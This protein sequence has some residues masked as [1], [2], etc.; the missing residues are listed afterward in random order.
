MAEDNV[1]GASS[2]KDM[3]P[4]SL[5]LGRGP[6][7]RDPQPPRDYRCWASVGSRLNDV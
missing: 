1:A 4:F 5:L 2:L 6:R 3:A 7:L